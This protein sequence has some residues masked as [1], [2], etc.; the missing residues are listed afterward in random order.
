M[1]IVSKSCR[2]PPCSVS[3][4]ASGHGGLLHESLPDFSQRGSQIPP[5]AGW[6][7]PALRAFAGLKNPRFDPME[8]VSPA[9]RAHHSHQDEC[10][11]SLPHARYS[12]LCKPNTISGRNA[13]AV[14]AGAYSC[15]SRGDPRLRRIAAKLT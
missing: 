14:A 6:T 4:V 3:T 8:L 1:R 11:A 2:I 5:V 12:A 10:P 13:S 7:H 9:D 15:S